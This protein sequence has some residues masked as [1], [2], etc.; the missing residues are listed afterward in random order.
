MKI[1]ELLV[2]FFSFWKLKGTTVIIKRPTFLYTKTV[3]LSTRYWFTH[4]VLY[5][6]LVLVWC[7]T[8]FFRDQTLSELH[9]H[10]PYTQTV[11]WYMYFTVWQ[12]SDLCIVACSLFESFCIKHESI[13][14]VCSLYIV[15]LPHDISS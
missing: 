6:Q 15:S 4:A 12:F 1:R 8:V 14:D 10:Y 5:V 7:S 11:F 13:I 2:W 9:I 3:L